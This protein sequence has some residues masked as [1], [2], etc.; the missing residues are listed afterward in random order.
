MRAAPAA[1]PEAPAVALPKIDLCVMLAGG[2]R[3][4]PLVAESGCSVLDFSISPTHTV[5]G[6][7][8]ERLAEAP[9]A[10]DDGL[11]VRVV[12]DERTPGPVI[13]TDTGPMRVVI[14]KEQR[15]FRGPAGIVRDEC[16]ALD[17]GATVLIVEA[18][19]LPACSITPLLAD[20]KRTGAA[21]TVAR[22]P[23]R[24]TAGLYLVRAEALELVPGNGFM[25]LKEQWL[26]KALGAG[27]DIRVASL[28]DP[29]VLSLRSRERFLE[30][31]QMLNQLPDPS[32]SIDEAPPAPEPEGVN[33]RSILSRTA[34]IAP[35]A[36]VVDSVIMEHAT[37]AAG[38]VVVRSLVC[39]RS[40]VPPDAVVT[41]SVLGPEAVHLKGAAQHRPR[42]RER[43]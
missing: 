42:N 23:D 17:P 30:A 13:E 25:D 34:T 12:H 29:G 37:V 28:P 32:E 36:V 19:R 18:G 24:S 33:R 39:P 27:F 16:A 8:I 35:G 41:D 4:S 5:L 14:R 9:A 20:H 31:V 2:Q 38:A 26:Q 22:N 43:R 7:W 15:A 11:E 3:A 40:V 1:S 10:S 6:A 21:I